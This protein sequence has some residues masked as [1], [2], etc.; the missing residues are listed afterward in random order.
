MDKK[1]IAAVLSAVDQYIKT[2]QGE[3]VP[4]CMPGVQSMWGIDS[5]R[6]MMNMRTLWQM[7]IFKK[8]TY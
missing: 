5:R 3:A 1:K 6:Q 7:K 4:S 8:A 2:E